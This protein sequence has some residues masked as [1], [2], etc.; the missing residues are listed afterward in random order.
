MVLNLFSLTDLTLENSSKILLEPYSLL[1][2]G[3]ND[4]FLKANIDGE[5]DNFGFRVLDFTPKE[6]NVRI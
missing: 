3:I 5:K 2:N 6:D 4:D 1:Y